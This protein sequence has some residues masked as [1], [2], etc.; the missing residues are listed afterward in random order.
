MRSNC[1]AVVGLFALV[2]TLGCH[3]RT[4][5]KPIA[6][7]PAPV[8]IV[9]PAP[10]LAPPPAPEPPPPAPTMDAADQALAL[11]KYED[12]ARE[13]EAYL[14]LTPPAAQRDEALFRL[15]LTYA[16]RA[17]WVR[18]ASTFK[19]LTDNPNSSLNGPA[20]LILSL[21]ADLTRATADKVERD[22]KIKQLNTELERLKRIDA[23]RGKRP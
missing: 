1:L 6:P 17:D 18:A 13:Y 8:A 12:A 11:A 21:H 22:Q 15:G 5:A 19:P 3:K 16:L 2:L 20:N 10:D 23:D 7:P 14:K 9:I 4:A